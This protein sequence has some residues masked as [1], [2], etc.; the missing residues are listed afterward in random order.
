VSRT[1]SQ[2]ERA[3]TIALPAARQVVLEDRDALQALSV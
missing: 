1:L 2:L 3:G